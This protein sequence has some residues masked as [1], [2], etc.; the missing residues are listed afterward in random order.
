MKIEK[1]IWCWGCDPKFSTP[2]VWIRLRP[3]LL[4]EHMNC[5]SESTNVWRSLEWRLNCSLCF[6][7]RQWPCCPTSFHSWSQPASSRCWCSSTSSRAAARVSNL[8]PAS[9]NCWTRSRCTTWTSA[10][11]CRASTSSATSRTTAFWCAAATEPSAGCCSV[12][13]TSARTASARR[14]RAPSSRWAPVTI[15]PASCDGDQVQNNFLPLFSHFFS[16]FFR[17]F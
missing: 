14:R 7:E 13:T 5:C 15:W 8:S 11:R 4:F 6:M 9:A 3:S 2:C 16:S 1:M 12:W 17:I 10:A